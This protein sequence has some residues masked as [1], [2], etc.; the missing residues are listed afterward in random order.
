MHHSRFAAPDPEAMVTTAA[1]QLQT[2][3]GKGG[4]GSTAAALFLEDWQ[5]YVRSRGDVSGALF[6]IDR[7][8]LETM[9]QEFTA[10]G[11]TTKSSRIA[12]ALALLRKLGCVH[13]VFTS[14]PRAVWWFRVPRRRKGRWRL[15]ALAT[16]LPPSWSS[17]WSAARGKELIS[18]PP[19][20][21]SG[22][23]AITPATNASG[24]G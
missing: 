18:S 20:S 11:S 12:P 7:C 9:A 23:M 16:L 1:L 24:C 22:R 8:D 14:L 2:V 15:Q 10:A 5:Q 6:P 13:Y 21:R 3:G 4:A 19:A 17:I